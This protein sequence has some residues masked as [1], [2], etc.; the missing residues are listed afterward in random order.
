MPTNKELQKMIG[1]QNRRISDLA[2]LLEKVAI[3]VTKKKE[4]PPPQEFLDKDTPLQVIPPKPKDTEV[5]P[6]DFKM[7]IPSA[8]KDRVARI[9]GSNFD[10]DLEETSG[11]NFLL[12][13]YMPRGFDRRQ[14]EERNQRTRDF[15]VGL[16][17]R[18]NEITDV[19]TWC[20]R[21]RENIMKVFP[22]FFKT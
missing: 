12:K 10:T 20:N 8:W 2:D 19:E 17:R 6:Q 16:V 13:I 15:T 1:D 21:M 7:P 11:G 3:E 22:E 5:P 18:G 4:E 14:G 9:L